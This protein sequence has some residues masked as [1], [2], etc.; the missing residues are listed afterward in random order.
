M[1]NNF[2]LK[3]VIGDLVNGEKSLVGALMKLQ[4]FAALTDNHM[5]IDFV[6]HELNGYPQGVILP[7]YRKAVNTIRV[8]LQF[9]EA[10]YSNLEIPLELIDEQYREVLRVHPII[11]S[12]AV[13]ENKMA[14]SRDKEQGQLLSME[15]PMV[16]WKLLQRAAGKLYKNEYYR[17]DVVGARLLTN[18]DI[19][20]KALTAIRSRL[21]SFVIE[22]SKSFG[23][24][25]E[26]DSFNK[27]QGANNEKLTSLFMNTVINNQGDGNLIN[28][29]TA[30]NIDAT[31]N[32]SKG[33]KEQFSHGLKSLGVEDSDIVE[34]NQ[35]IEEEADSFETKSLGDKSIDWITK[36]SGKA[37]KGIGSISKGVTSSVLADLVKQYFGI[38]L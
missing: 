5:L 7:E 19:I 22:I 14:L 36:V 32:I 17:A 21:L 31:I 18:A 13:L 38:P 4:Y 20:P 10:A 29:G 26:I 24:N 23:Y 37:L 11:Q 3:E 34:I 9:G 35:I 6:L 25:I 2:I 12:V 8:D 16:H 28:T 27:T 1:E 30:A 15:I 33:D